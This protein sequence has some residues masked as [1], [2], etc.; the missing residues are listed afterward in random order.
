MIHQLEVVEFGASATMKLIR[1]DMEQTRWA[2]P[3]LAF[4]RRKITDWKFHLPTP[5]PT[6]SA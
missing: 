3:I 2:G 1:H 5:C 4:V 6:R